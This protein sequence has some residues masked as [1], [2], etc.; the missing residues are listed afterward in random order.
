MIVAPTC[1]NAHRHA[2]TRADMQIP[3]L[4]FV[5]WQAIMEI[6]WRRVLDGNR[7]RTPQPPDNKA[8]HR[9]RLNLRGRLVR[10]MFASLHFI[11]LPFSLIQDC[12]VGPVIANVIQLGKTRA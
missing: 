10:R 5:Q 1:G 2:G 12:Q 3:G 4:H 8:M 7:I 11:R 6:L 9:S